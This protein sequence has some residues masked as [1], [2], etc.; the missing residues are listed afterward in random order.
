MPK[1]LHSLPK[2]RDSLSF[3]YLEKAIIEQDALSIVAIQGE[4]RIPIPIAAMTVLMLGPGISITHAAVKT[5]SDCGCMVVWCGEKAAKF[6][7]YGQG[8]TR[9]SENLLR[10]AK[11]CMDPELHMQVVYRMYARRFPDM[12]T[13]GMTLQQV[14]GL[15]GIR[16]REA[17]KLASRSTGVKWTKRDY[18]SDNW[19]DADPVNRAL[20]YANTL[21]YSVCQAAIMSLGY[22]PGL[23]FIHTGKMLSFV[24]DVA[25]LYK[26]ETTIPAAFEAVSAGGAEIEPQ[27]RRCFR[28]KLH[29]QKVMQKIADDIAFVLGI[30]E[31]TEARTVSVAG[32]LW[33]GADAAVSGGKGYSWEEDPNW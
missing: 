27:V 2:V 16:V 23:G 4:S 14:R 33:D 1:D 11:A 20:S 17:Y 29:S 8:E 12:D 19:D 32:E 28:S 24:Y 13:S 30:K 21:L 31:D 7:A 15:E 18:K 3:L 22:S 26:A 25:D 9:S 6:Y 10:Q 5:L